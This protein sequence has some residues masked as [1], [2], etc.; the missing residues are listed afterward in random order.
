MLAQVQAS[1][2]SIVSSH[3]EPSLPLNCPGII[4]FVGSFPHWFLFLCVSSV[5][6]KYAVGLLSASFLNPHKVYSISVSFALLKNFA[7]N[8]VMS[9]DIL[10][11]VPVRNPIGG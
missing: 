2:M 4:L 11:D 7:A 10:I 1:Y 6:G 8:E 9:A 5:K 3:V